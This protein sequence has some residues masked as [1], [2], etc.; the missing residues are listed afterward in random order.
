MKELGKY[1]VSGTRIYRGHPPGTVFEAFIPAGAEFR[2]IQR[3][4]ITLLERVPADLK[5]GSYRLPDG[6][7][8]TKQERKG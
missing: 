1:H 5:P 2:A 4:S 3:G 8:S 7:P 6:W